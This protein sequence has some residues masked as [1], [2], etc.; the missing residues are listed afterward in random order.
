VR[1]AAGAASPGGE[2]M[3]NAR[4]QTAAEQAARA[5]YGRLV[6]LLA[7]RAGDIASAE[8]ALA[9]ALAAALRQWP[10]E[11]VPDSADAWL[12]TVARRALS[13]GYRHARVRDAAE[14]AIMMIDAERAD[15]P[16]N[17]FPDERLKLLFVCAHPAIDRAIHTPLMLQAVLGIDAARIAAAFLVAPAA[18][19]QRLVRAKAKIR[20]AGIGFV[21][22]EGDQLPARMAA[23]L[24]AV[25]AAYGTGWD[26]AVAVD[27]RYAGLA[28]EA[29]FLA[30]LLVEMLPEAADAWGL[31]ALLLHCEARRD[32]RRDAAGGYVPLD[33]QDHALWSRDLVGEAERALGRAAA[34]GGYGP[35]QTEAAIQ[36]LHVHGRLT[37]LDVRATICGLYDVLAERDPSIGRLIARAVAHGAWSGA[38]TG[39]ALLAALPEALVAAHQ[40]YW[41]ARAHLLGAAGRNAEAHAAYARAIGLAGDP[42]VQAFLRDRQA[43]CG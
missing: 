7:A 29:V 30:R 15:R 34:L 1:G 18:M 3:E 5:S 6:A 9:E 33:R 26:D 38:K 21:V 13:A 11:G 28:G 25:Y 27:G 2:L 40:P 36:S 32:A 22:P 37:G 23:V 10:L 20:D 8:D 41:A 31:L 12:L 42:A 35:Y 43:G 39:L 4:A 14:E 19:G 17:A 16:E 24:D